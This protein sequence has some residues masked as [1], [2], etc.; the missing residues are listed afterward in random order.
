[1]SHFSDTKSKKHFSSRSEIITKWIGSPR[2]FV[3]HSL[4]FILC[5]LSSVLDF[6]AFDHMLLVL[7]TV[8]SLEAIYLSIFIQM[9]VNR[10]TASLKEV[11]EDI[12]EIQKDVDEI[13]EDIDEIQDDEEE[14]R[15]QSFD[16]IERD[17]K[18]LLTDISTLRGAMPTKIK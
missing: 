10:Q 15:A 11:E 12:D 9:T 8:V 1:M 4:F 5:F 7:T 2:S 13:Q 6:V 17:L 14:T 18:K 16:T 3:V